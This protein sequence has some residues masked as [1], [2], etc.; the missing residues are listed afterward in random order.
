ML[1]HDIIVIGAS[2]GGVESLRTLTRGL[3]ADLPAAVLVVL[4]LPATGTSFLPTILER[5]GRL[6]ASHAKDG[7]PI[8]A[9]RIYIAPPDY[10]LLVEPDCLRLTRGTRENNYRPAIDPLFRTAAMS[11][12]PRVVG[13]VLSGALD[14]GTAGL[15]AVK[16]R[17][18]IGIVQDPDEALFDGMPRSAIEHAAPDYVLPVAHIGSLLARLAA[19]PIR[20]V[21]V[22]SVTEEMAMEARIVAMDA[23]ALHGE[24]HPGTP[25]ALGC[26]ACGGALWE[27]EDERLVRFRCRTGHAYSPETLLAEQS[28]TLEQ[29]LWAAQR[30]LEEQASLA[31]RLAARAES[32]DRPAAARRF[33][34]QERDAVRRAE[35]IRQAL[36]SDW[37]FAERTGEASE[38]DPDVAT[39]AAGRHR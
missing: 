15:I 26:P 36:A 24:R 7:E 2:A 9:G 11:F 14:D 32:V 8:V 16:R 17:G 34:V 4:H 1:T 33:Q 21:A 12:G 19:E 22:A 39:T 38:P 25:S 27:I 20:E 18:G 30:V 37:N 28:D 23:E 13:V 5:G 3:P 6:P 35:V 29:A 10:H 31:R